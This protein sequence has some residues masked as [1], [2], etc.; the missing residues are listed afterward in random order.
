MRVC[1][2]SFFIE[3]LIRAGTIITASPVRYNKRNL[4]TLQH[5]ISRDSPRSRSSYSLEDFVKHIVV[6]TVEFMGD[7]FNA[8]LELPFFDVYS[9]EIAALVSSN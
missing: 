8:G 1:A 3:M 4:S 7:P 9:S 2:W 6:R 5:C